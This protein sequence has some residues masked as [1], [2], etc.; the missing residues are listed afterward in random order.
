LLVDTL[1]LALAVQVQP[2]SLQDCDGGNEVLSA[3]TH[4]HWRLSKVWADGS[5]RGELEEWV[6]NQMT[7]VTSFRS[8][9]LQHS[10]LPASLIQRV[11]GSR[12]PSMYL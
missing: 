4:K 3:L 11:D 8:V 9:W 7:S 1:G 12:I 5:Y 2:V 10:N 6:W